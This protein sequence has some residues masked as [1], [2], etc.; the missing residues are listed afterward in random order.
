M[1]IGEVFA[2]AL[3]G[4]STETLDILPGLIVLV[5]A[6]IGLRGNINT[7]MGSRLGSAVHMGLRNPLIKSF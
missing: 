7:T 3:F 6:L 5:P 1:G 2:G 4:H